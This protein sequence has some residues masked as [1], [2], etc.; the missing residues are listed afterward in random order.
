[1]LRK[2]NLFKRQAHRRVI[3]I[4]AVEK[5]HIPV[6]VPR[7]DT[8]EWTLCEFNKTQYHKAG[9]HNRSCRT[10]YFFGQPV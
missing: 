1:M 4:N 7:V 10:H 9:N 2:F 5:D 6:P 8:C 3:D